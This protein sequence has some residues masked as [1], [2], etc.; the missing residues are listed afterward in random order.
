MHGS[1]FLKD[2]AKLVEYGVAVTYCILF[3][4][5]WRFIHGGKEAARG[6][7]RQGRRIRPRRHRR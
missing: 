4:G 6:G 5:F 7:G 2:S 3:V 1:E